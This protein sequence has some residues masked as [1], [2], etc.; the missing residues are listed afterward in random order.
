MLAKI[1]PFLVAPTLR[2]VPE[3]YRDARRVVLFSAALLLWVPVYTA[4]FWILG[5][6]FSSLTVLLAGVVLIL[7]LAAFRLSGS[8]TLGR[9]AVIAIAFSVYFVLAHLSGGTAAPA[10]AWFTT[11]PLIA[12]GLRGSLWWSS[13]SILAIGIIYAGGMPGL[14]MK[15]E[16]TP[17]AMRFLQFSGFAGLVACVLIFTMLFHILEQNARKVLDDALVQA[18]AADV[19]KD[20]FLANMTHELRT[21]MTAILG[22]AEAIQ[23]QDRDEELIDL[24]AETILRNGRHL[25][26]IVNDVLDLSKLDSGK[27]TV[28]LLPVSPT[29]IADDVIRL[30]RGRAEERNLELSVE[31]IGEIPETIL[32]DSRRL[33]QILINLIGNAIKFTETG[34][35]RLGIRGDNLATDRPRLIFE[36]HDSGIGLTSEQISRLFIPFSQADPSTTRRYGGT[37]LGLVISQRLAE[38]L[39]GVITVTSIPGAGSTFSLEINL[40]RHSA[41]GPAATGGS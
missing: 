29:N 36:V 41:R 39:G 5:A 2:E 27:L 26:E 35:V 6:P 32:S 17:D 9:Q 16:L 13:A 31:T 3:A 22:Y 25:L 11:I 37:G 8:L 34:G 4:I 33:R 12:V 28:E 10:T 1:W 38:L 21:P 40:P 14:P 7:S 30:L 20:Q 24:A 15:N 19:V 18:H 23:D